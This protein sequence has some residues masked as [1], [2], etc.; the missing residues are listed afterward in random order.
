MHKINFI[1]P[2]VFE[3]LRILIASLGIPEHFRAH[4]FEIKSSICNFNRYVP[5]CKKSALYLQYFLRYQSLKILQSDWLQALFFLTREPDFSQ[6]CHFNR[7][8]KVIMAHDLNSKNLHF[9][10]Q[11]SLQNF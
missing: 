6:P 4:P 3:I 5:A 9:N 1:P 7:I 10:G 2:L 8:I 11:I